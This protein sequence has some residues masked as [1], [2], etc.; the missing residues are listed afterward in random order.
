LLWPN[1]LSYRINVSIESQLRPSTDLALKIIAINGRRQPD[2]EAGKMPL[3]HFKL[4]HRWQ[5]TLPIPPIPSIQIQI[6]IQI[7]FQKYAKWSEQIC[8]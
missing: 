4:A 8:S 1:Q 7:Q 3:W 2:G 6:Q 5:P